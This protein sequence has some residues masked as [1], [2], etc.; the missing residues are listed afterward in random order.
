MTGASPGWNDKS[1]LVDRSV[2]LNYAL[3]ISLKTIQEKVQVATAH[4]IFGGS[5]IPKFRSN[6][7]FSNVL[8]DR[9]HSAKGMQR[10]VIQ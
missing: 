8:H 9:W 10:E 2:M 3:R 4:W 7:S 6:F 5:W 1:G